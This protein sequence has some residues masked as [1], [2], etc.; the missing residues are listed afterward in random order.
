MGRNGL[1][2]L[3][4]RTSKDTSEDGMSTAT[5]P[6]IEFDEVAHT[7][8]VEGR[9]LISVTQVLDECGLVSPFCKGEEYR[10][11]GRAVH[12]ACQ[13]V[14]EGDLNWT[15]IKP[16]WVGYVK[17]WEKFREETGFLSV[18]REL[19]VVDL[20]YGYAGTLDDH[21]L[22]GKRPTIVDKKTGAIQACARLQLAAYGNAKEPGKLFDRIAVGLKPD[23]TYS[24]KVYPAAEFQH[25]LYDFLAFLRTVVWKRRY[26]NG[27]QSNGS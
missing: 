12:M 23:G 11:R 10:T 4:G 7:Y 3:L 24:M 5:R 27:N 18:E 22:R 21:G 14:D 26:G 16:E 19:R 25:D 1:L 6:E 17:A 8:K 9:E 2:F 20:T 15:T 13:F